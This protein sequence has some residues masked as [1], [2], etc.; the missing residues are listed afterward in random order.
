MP[1]EGRQQPKG[2]PHGAV[3]RCATASILLLA[4]GHFWLGRLQQSESLYLLQK[5]AAVYDVVELERSL[6]STQVIEKLFQS[7]ARVLGVDGDRPQISGVAK[8]EKEFQNRVAAFQCPATGFVRAAHEILHQKQ[9]V[10]Q[11]GREK[12][13]PFV[14]FPTA[15]EAS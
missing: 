5:I 9:L 7:V 13:A 3:F 11:H 8:A 14:H 6:T 12:Q 1:A 4:R 10:K 15:L 2:P